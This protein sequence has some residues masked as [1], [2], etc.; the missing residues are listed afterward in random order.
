MSIRRCS[1]LRSDSMYAII[2]FAV[3]VINFF[4]L[5]SSFFPQTS[6]L[7]PQTSDAFSVAKIMLLKS[8]AFIPYI[9]LIVGEL[10]FLA[11]VI[12]QV[13]MMS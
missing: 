13:C 5:P 11:A 7:I 2:S 12:E 9:G 6:A 10:T 3:I 4:L 1:S 8:T